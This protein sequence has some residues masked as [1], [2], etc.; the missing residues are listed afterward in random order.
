MLL[1]DYTCIVG[2]LTEIDIWYYRTSKKM[3]EKWVDSFK[4]IPTTLWLL[5]SKQGKS[6][7][8]GS[9]NFLVDL[10]LYTIRSCFIPYSWNSYFQKH[11][12]PLFTWWSMPSINFFSSGESSERSQVHFSDHWCYCIKDCKW[13][14]REHWLSSWACFN[15]LIMNHSFSSLFSTE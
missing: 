3:V 7:A 9:L 4:L 8:W 11:T 15:F 10:G 5:S 1:N 12:T 13:R 14:R 6:G 2:C